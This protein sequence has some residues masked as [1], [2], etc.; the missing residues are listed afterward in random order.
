MFR[1]FVNWL[2]KKYDQALDDFAT[3]LKPPPEKQVLDAY[4]YRGQMYLERRQDGDEELALKDFSSVIAKRPAGH[5]ASLR[6][7]RI[8]FGRMDGQKLPKGLKLAAVL[9]GPDKL[10]DL[11]KDPNFQQGMKDL[12]AFI[13]R[14]ERF[15]PDG[16][17][18]CGRR[19]LL[20]HR[21]IGELP[22]KVQMAQRWLALD[23]LNRA[24]K[25][26]A[27]SYQVYDELG[28]ALVGLGHVREA[29]AAFNHAIKLA[30]EQAQAPMWRK[31]GWQ[32]E[33][34]N[35]LPGALEA[36][37]KAF[38]RAIELDP[39]NAEGYAGL[40]YIQ[41]SLGK[42]PAAATSKA[43][44]AALLAPGDW[45]QLHNVACVY[46]KLAGK[47]HM[48]KDTKRA[49][50]YEDV[51]LEILKRE[52][53]LWERDRTGGNAPHQIERDGAFSPELRTRP[54]FQELIKPRP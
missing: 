19:G 37:A 47:A 14:A 5:A 13:A 4:F 39:K 21:M 40:G 20:M 11:Q 18:A 29:V 6:R 54:E 33:A 41:A 36:A 1:G 53:D 24:I 7:A 52:V 51:T 43:V 25:G 49:R 23:Q 45:L 31:L 38:A 34:L 27:G 16:P 26:G 30:P 50:E 22:A 3:A 8:Y 44:K 42:A 12:N 9:K 48:G 17:E 28:A 32:Y 35:R 46:G 15:D 2:E 10:A